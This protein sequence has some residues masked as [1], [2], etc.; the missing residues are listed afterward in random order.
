MDLLS[1]CLD[2]L[3]QTKITATAARANQ[4][5]PCSSA[6]IRGK[7]LPFSDFPPLPPFLCVAKVLPFPITRFFLIS[8]IR[9]NQW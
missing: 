7:F 9:V 6:F 4:R 8:V 1:Q 5:F 2:K 3:Q